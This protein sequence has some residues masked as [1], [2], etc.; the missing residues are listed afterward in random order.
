VILLGA[1]AAR[2]DI[3]EDVWERTLEE[4]I[5]PKLLKLNQRAFAAGLEM[6]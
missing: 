2:L 6:A 3:P 5:P 1:L 4:R